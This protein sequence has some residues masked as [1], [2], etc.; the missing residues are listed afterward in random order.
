[1]QTVV[2]PA[3]EILVEAG[4]WQQRTE[5]EAIAARVVEAALKRLP[6]QPTD[7]E[8]LSFV[9]T[10]DDH[11]R[12]L[13]RRYRNIDKATNV[14]SFPMAAAVGR[15]GMLLGDIVLARETIVSEAASQGLTVEAHMAHLILHGFLHVLG[16]DHAEDAEAQAMERLETEILGDLGISDP[17]APRHSEARQGI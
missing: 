14:L 1:M 10:D 8:E 15:S 16:Y 17:H 3:I 2:R 13:N 11:I 6:L 7:D 9:F 4:A 5:L 12:A